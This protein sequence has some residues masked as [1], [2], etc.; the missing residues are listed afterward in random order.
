[1]TPDANAG[2]DFSLSFLVERA[3]PEDR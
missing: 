1:V 2:E 3:G